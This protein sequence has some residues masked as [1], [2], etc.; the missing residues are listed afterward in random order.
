MQ[1]TQK[2]FFILAGCPAVQNFEFKLFLVI[3]I[4]FPASEAWKRYWFHRFLLLL[5]H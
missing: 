2:R 5:C 4:F 3:L 1:D